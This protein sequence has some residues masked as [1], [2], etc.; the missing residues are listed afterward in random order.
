MRAGIDD[1]LQQQ[2]SRLSWHKLAA[3]ANLCGPY[4]VSNPITVCR[5]R[6]IL[7]ILSWVS[8]DCRLWI[9]ESSGSWRVLLSRGKDKYRAR[10]MVGAQF[11]KA[12]ANQ[13]RQGRLTRLI[14][15]SRATGEWQIVGKDD[16]AEVYDRV[17][18]AIERAYSRYCE[19]GKWR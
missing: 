3:L 17:E 2:S 19:S 14:A 7:G 1:L 15:W 12:D 9:E 18:D 4:D 10:D 5:R 8:F 6:L 16:A 13:A 11:T